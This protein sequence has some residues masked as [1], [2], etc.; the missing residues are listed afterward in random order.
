MYQISLTNNSNVDLGFAGGNQ[1]IPSGGG[2]WKSENLGDVTILV[3][4]RGPLNFHDIADKHI[5]GDSGETWGVLIAYQGEEIV[6]R[7]EGGGQLTVTI[8]DRY[9]AVLGGMHLRQIHLPAIELEGA[10]HTAVE[11]PAEGEAGA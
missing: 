2:H 10:M 3:P 7:Y 9:Q 5:G 1:L 6:G 11:V 4:T 8:N